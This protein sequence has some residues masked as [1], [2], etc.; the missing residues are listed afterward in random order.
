MSVDGTPSDL[1]TTGG[2]GI[3]G[4]RLQAP[5]V[6]AHI[7]IARR[8]RELES[9][10]F[11]RGLHLQKQRAFLYGAAGRDRNVPDDT[12]GRGLELVFHFHRFHDYETLPSAHAVT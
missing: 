1:A 8:A 4:A 3:C 12:R 5:I 2:A 11:M 6:T 7:V 10:A 9:L